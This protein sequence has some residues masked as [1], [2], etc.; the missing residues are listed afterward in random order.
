MLTFDHI[1]YYKS[2]VV[3][4]ETLSIVMMQMFYVLRNLR[5]FAPICHGFD[6]ESR[7]QDSGAR[8]LRI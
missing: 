8:L 3:A 7:L 1:H 2:H 6:G 4:Y 5:Y